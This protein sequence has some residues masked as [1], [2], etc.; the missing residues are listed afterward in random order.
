MFN[1][2]YLKVIF[3]KYID[4]Y[5]VIFQL[6]YGDISLFFLIDVLRNETEMKSFDLD[7]AAILKAVDSAPLCSALYES[8]KASDN[9]AK[10]LKD[11]KSLAYVC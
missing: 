5:I 1:I 4:Y 11:R 6:S 9:V 3:A 8:I 2:I 7:Q 10:Y